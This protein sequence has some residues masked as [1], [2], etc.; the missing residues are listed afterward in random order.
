M[1]RADL[2]VLET[3]ILHRAIEEM[4]R[5]QGEFL[6]G[7]LEH[8]AQGGASGDQAA[9]GGRPSTHGHERRIAVH[10]LDIC[11]R[12]AQRIRHHLGKDRRRALAVR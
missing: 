1:P 11:W 8:Q 6:L 5:E 9:A 4:G 10:H 7:L 2:P 12:H 3:E